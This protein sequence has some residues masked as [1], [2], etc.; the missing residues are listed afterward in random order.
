MHSPDKEVISENIKNAPKQHIKGKKIGTSITCSDVAA[1]SGFEPEQSESE[2]LVLPLHYSAMC[3]S[4]QYYYT[5][6]SPQCQH[7][8]FSFGLFVQNS[9][10]FFENKNL[11]I[12]I[13]QYHILMYTSP[14]LCPHSTA[15]FTSR[16]RTASNH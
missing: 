3:Q 4:Q 9:P 1:E 11:I 6:I 7:F 15:Q 12:K 14:N 2:S 8:S 16:K 5:T 10:I 13:K